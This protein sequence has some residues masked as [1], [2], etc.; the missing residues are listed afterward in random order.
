[1]SVEIEKKFLIS[2]NEA[3]WL[4]ENFPH[5]TIGIIQWYLD[6]VRD[7]QKSERIRLILNKDG[8]KIWIKG[9]KECID[10]NLIYRR[11]EETPLD[12]DSIPIDELRD[13]PFIIKLRSVFELPFQAEVVLDHFLDNPYCVYDVRDLLEIELKN[14]EVPLEK[15][16]DQILCFLKLHDLKDVSENFN[17]ANHTIALR[18][19]YI[20]GMKTNDVVVLTDF[21]RKEMRGDSVEKG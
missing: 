21:L 6:G 19:M 8:N 11:E 17:Y 18:S 7:I 10:Q 16:V 4:T 13:F 3:M 20:N 9:K 14:N 5:H 15:T 2:H 12:N 1:M